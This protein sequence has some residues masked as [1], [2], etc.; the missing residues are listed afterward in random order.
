MK[1]RDAKTLGPQDKRERVF[2]STHAA[3]MW[4][5]SMA[6]HGWRQDGDLETNGITYRARLTR[7]KV[8]VKKR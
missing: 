8:E 3:M 4:V 5:A 6:P 2:F 7:P 1:L